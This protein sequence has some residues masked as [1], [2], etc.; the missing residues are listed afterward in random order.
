MLQW[1]HERRATDVLFA[2]N[3]M[4]NLPFLLLVELSSYGRSVLPDLKKSIGFC[5]VK[6]KAP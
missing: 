1:L 4:A 6:G 5:I 2:L 3:L